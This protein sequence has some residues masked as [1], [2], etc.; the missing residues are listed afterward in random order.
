MK[1]NPEKKNWLEN[2]LDE[3]HMRKVIDLKPQI[4]AFLDE[5]GEKFDCRTVT[6]EI[7]M[8]NDMKVVIDIYPEEEGEML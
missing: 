7:S 6:S 8:G 4:Y 2:Y 1:P 3:N 5:A